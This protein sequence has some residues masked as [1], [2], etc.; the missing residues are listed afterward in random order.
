M[1]STAKNKSTTKSTNM[2]EPVAAFLNASSKGD[3]HA[4]YMTNKTRN[5]CH[6]LHKFTE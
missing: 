3:D 1:I 5:V 2:R 6:H 4:E